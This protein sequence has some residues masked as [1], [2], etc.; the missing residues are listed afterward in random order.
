MHFSVQM[1]SLS[2]SF[3]KYP[4]MRI[5]LPA[6]FMNDKMG[7]R[8]KSDFFLTSYSI[9]NRAKAKVLSFHSTQ[10]LQVSIVCQVPGIGVIGE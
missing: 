8:R 10:F 4:A 1:Y 6:I 7:S 5:F 3:S 9:S 2:Q